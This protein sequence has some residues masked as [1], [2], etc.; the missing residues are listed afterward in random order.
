MT[1]PLVLGTR[2]SRLALIQTDL[3]M[4][5]LASSRPDIAAVPRMIKTSGDWK[6]EDGERRLSE[7]EGGKGLFVKE[8]EQAILAGTVHAGVHCLKDVPSFLP[9]G[10]VVEHV[11]PREDPRDVFITRTGDDLMSL[12]SGSVV[13]TSSLRRQA[14]I[15]R[16]RPDLVVVP[17]RGN[18]TTRLDKIKQGQVDATVLAQAGINRLGPAVLGSTSL[19]AVPLPPSVMLP[20]CGQGVIVIESRADDTE[21]RAVLNDI[22]HKHT[23]LCVS[24]ERLVLQILDGSCHT[25][26]GVHAVL[27]NGTMTVYAMVATPEGE[28]SYASER[29]GSVQTIALV[30]AQDLGED[31]R[32][33]AP[34][35]LLPVRRMGT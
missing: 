16:L 14:T 25:P 11:L 31:V 27:E 32:M 9:P 12:P 21:T 2:G 26:I 10:L 24:A 4:A 3:V 8:I 15:K 17:L 29:S 18:V 13:G 23:G 30:L 28:Q 35:G 33:H 7:V 19:R 6:P 1:L 20:A 34:N 5:A 22:H